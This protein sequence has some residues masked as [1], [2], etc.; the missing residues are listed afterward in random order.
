M[1]RLFAIEFYSM[2][3]GTSLY[4]VVAADHR[5]AMETATSHYSESGVEPFERFEVRLVSENLLFAEPS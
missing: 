2:N 1:R 5:K 3:A 4:Y